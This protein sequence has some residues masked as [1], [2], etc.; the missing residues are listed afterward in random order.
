MAHTGALYSVRV[1]RKGPGHGDDYQPLGDINGAGARLIQA[2]DGYLPELNASTEDQMKDVTVVSHHLEGDA[3][4]VM[5]HQGQR[6]IA[7]DIYDQTGQHKARQLPVDTHEVACGALFRLPPNETTGWLCAHV[8]N[9]RSVK[10]LLVDEL[11]RMFRADF[12]DLML[13]VQ[14]CALGAA[15]R[16]AVAENRIGAVKLTKLD[17]PHDRANTG[18][19]KWVPSESGARLTLEIKGWHG[20]KL[21][22]D[23]IRRFLEG[24]QGVFG[25]ITEFDGLDFDEAHVSVELEDGKQR[26]FSL[27]NPDGGHALSQELEGLKWDDQ[28]NPIPESLFAALSEV[29][30]TLPQ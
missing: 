14:P 21:V 9:G 18:A 8:N 12:S 28:G 19:G 5:L 16:K 26:T 7:A 1:R 20:S 2:L 27:H 22:P 17:R 25:E 30:D 3:L 13:E 11:R 24:E 10:A 23:R 15:V 4:L 6:G 29:I